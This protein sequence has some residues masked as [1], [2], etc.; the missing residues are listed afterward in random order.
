MYTLV[1]LF[2]D[3][4]NYLVLSHC[5][6]LFVLCFNFFLLFFF[7]NTDLITNLLQAN[8]ELQKQVGLLE[9]VTRDQEPNGNCCESEC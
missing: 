3:K 5:C 1:M 8:K 6:N 2:A 7:K 9:E 4:S